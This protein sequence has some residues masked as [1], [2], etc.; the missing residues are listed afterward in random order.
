MSV[1]E[2]LANQLK[3]RG[4]LSSADLGSFQPTSAA[5]GLEDEQTTKV[6]P[7]TETTIADVPEEARK[8]VVL[9]VAER[10]TAHEIL[11]DAVRN[12]P[13]GF[14]MDEN[15]VELTPEDKEEFLNAVVNNSRFER[16]FSL[17]NDRLCGT[18]RSR[19][20]RESRA[21]L[22]EMRRQL[23]SGE[24]GSDIEYTTRLRHALLIFQIKELNGEEIPPPAE[25]L[26]AQAVVE[27]DA[28][29]KPVKKTVPPTWVITAEVMFEGDEARTSALYNELAV[30]EAKYWTL[31]A[32]A[33]NQDFWKT[34]GSTSE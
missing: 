20:N 5:D 18:F 22:L 23:V 12:N 9:T 25:P 11:A 32:Q 3:E 4:S 13:S 7:M 1:K 24:M 17:F 28:A 14:V 31:V 15:K 10:R 21:I 19:L 6:D 26:A 33:N 29:G 2:R 27:N 16:P 8:D 30:F 34:E